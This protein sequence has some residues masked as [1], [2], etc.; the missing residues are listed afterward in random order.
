MATLGF[1]ILA[2]IAS[3]VTS[4]M[5]ASIWLLIIAAMLG[6]PPMSR[7]VSGSMFCSLKN[8][9]SI[10]TKYGSEEAVGN[11]PTLT[12]SCA[13]APWPNAAVT[14]TI[15]PSATDRIVRLASPP[16]LMAS[17]PLF[18]RACRGEPGR[19]HVRLRRRVL[20]RPA[21]VER[22]SPGHAEEGTVHRLGAADAR[23]FPAVLGAARALSRRAG[24]SQRHFR[25]ALHLDVCWS[26]ARRADG[27]FARALRV[28]A[29]SC[30]RSPGAV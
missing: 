19:R 1:L 2:F 6:G 20:R 18:H 30:R 12:L 8:P 5:A 26:G 9:R 17:V 11:T 16:L 29:R 14:A 10:A 7:M 28:R 13:A 21:S 23:L 15:A 3:M 25:R 27:A 22:A 4:T 24:R